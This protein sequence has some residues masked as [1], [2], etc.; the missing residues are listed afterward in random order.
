M[1]YLVQRK[2]KWYNDDGTIQ[3]DD[4]L[5]SRIISVVKVDSRFISEGDEVYVSLSRYGVIQRHV[6]DNDRL[7]ITDNADIKA[8]DDDR[9]LDSVFGKTSDVMELIKDIYNCR[10]SYCNIS[11]DDRVYNFLQHELCLTDQE[12]IQLTLHAPAIPSDAVGKVSVFM[13]AADRR[14]GRRTTIKIGRF[15]RMIRDF[16]SDKKVELISNAFKIKYTP[17]DFTLHVSS[18]RPAFRYAY[19][20]VRCAYQ[21]PRTTSMR[22]SI[23]SS[24]MHAVSCDDDGTSPAEVYASGDFHIAWVT[25]LEDGKERLGGRVIVRNPVD[26]NPPIHGPMY[27]ACEASL[28]KL[29]EYLETIGATSTGSWNG[30]KLLKL[31]GYH[32]IIA[33]YSDMDS[34]VADYGDF[35]EFCNYGDYELSSTDGFIAEGEYCQYCEDRFDMDHEGAYVEGAGPTCQHCLDEHYVYVEGDGEYAH[36]EDCI[37]VNYRYSNSTFQEWRREDGM[38]FVY[39]ECEEEFWCENHVEY[40]ENMDDYVPTHK[41]EDYP[42]FYPQDEEEEKDAA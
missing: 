4:D 25:T 41:I 39:S 23:A 37:M 34:T 7:I 11:E 30:A 13:N 19:K 38:D 40:S 2:V 14:R 35:L 12:S 27:G 28:D 15:V 29:Q 1:L 26:G 6:I 8:I 22:K 31:H 42:E 36:V 9:I 5:H 10:G 32:G 3:F 33:P 20:G 21:D 17:R 18:T 16:T 24:C